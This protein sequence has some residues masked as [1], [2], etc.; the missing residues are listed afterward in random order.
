MRPADHAPHR[1]A[2]HGLG[3][4]HEPAVHRSGVLGQDTP[5]QRHENRETKSWQPCY[6]TAP[7]ILNLEKGTL[8][9][10]CALLQ[11]W[12]SP[13]QT[14]ELSIL[15]ACRAHGGRGATQGLLEHL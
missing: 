3:G 8:R 13:S 7:N 4:P 6:Q 9:V 10:I 2:N 12:V 14:R 15:P 1:A 11:E 5:F